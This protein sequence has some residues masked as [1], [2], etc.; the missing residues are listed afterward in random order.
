MSKIIPLT[1]IIK[2]GLILAVLLNT[3]NIL[4]SVD[5]PYMWNTVEVTAERDVSIKLVR[6]AESLKIKTFLLK[7]EGKKINVADKWFKDI[8]QPEFRTLKVTWGCG[9]LTFDNDGNLSSP[10]C[11]IHISF[12]FMIDFGEIDLP[13][14]YENPRV[15]F[16]I[17]NGS[18]SKRLIQ[19]KEA[20]DRWKSYWLDF[21]VNESQG[22]IKK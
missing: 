22:A 14:W 12:N 5:Q 9:S 21:S 8:T 4:A 16:Y 1:K 15:T 20:E 11:S 10:S 13:V 17:E 7:I 19:K 18:V 3:A 2:R 6:D